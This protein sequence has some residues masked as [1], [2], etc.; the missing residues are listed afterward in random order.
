MTTLKVTSLIDMRKL[1]VKVF[2]S[3][4]LMEAKIIIEAWTNAIFLGSA[5]LN[6]DENNPFIMSIESLIRL[7]SIGQAVESGKWIIKNEKLFV[8]EPLEVT[9]EIISRLSL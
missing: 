3:I 4:G 2:P 6:P 9:P 1:L 8:N 7:L 5:D